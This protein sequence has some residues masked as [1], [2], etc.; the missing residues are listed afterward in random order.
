M[1]SWPTFPCHAVQLAPPPS[2]A[3]PESSTVHLPSAFH[4]CSSVRGPAIAIA[5]AALL[6]SCG[7]HTAVSPGPD[8]SRPSADSKVPKASV[9]DTTM[10]IRTPSAERGARGGTT[11]QLDVVLARDVPLPDLHA[12]L[13]DNLPRFMVP[14]YLE[15]RD[16]FPKTPSE[17][18]EKWRFAGEGVDRPGVLD[19]GDR[20]G[21]RRAVRGG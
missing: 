20:A 16:A 9:E 8:A 15:R 12:W 11:L 3:T 18:V 7:D 6:L 21:D 14:R 19:A 10:M 1:P 13:A 17:R 5:A 4:R 2:A